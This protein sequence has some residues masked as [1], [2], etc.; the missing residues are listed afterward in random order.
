M[1]AIVPHGHIPI[2]L[3][4]A[5]SCKAARLV[6][7]EY[8][9]TPFS[10]YPGQLTQAVEATRY[11]M[12][13]EGVSADKLIIAGDSAGGHLTCSLLAHIVE[14]APMVRPLDLG[15]KQLRA[16]VLIS[17]WLDFTPES[18]SVLQNE[19]YDYL[20]QSLL[21]M[22]GAIFK[23]DAQHVWSEPINAP[24]AKTL[25]SRAF[26]KTRGGKRVVSRV[27]IT[28]GEREVLLDSC[29]KFATEVVGAEK[30]Y[31]DGSERSVDRVKQASAILVVGPSEVHVQ[32]ALDLVLRYRRGATVVAIKSF[33]EAV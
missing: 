11:L 30:V 28:A 31:W 19:K 13:T 22:L 29:V 33:L 3:H 26:P 25:W 21:M 32:C 9:L 15:G 20:S 2:G 10:V 17:P 14:P 4:L 6:F 1:H 27:I 12:E 7:L 23:S 8:T 24:S 5:K 16:A 18:T